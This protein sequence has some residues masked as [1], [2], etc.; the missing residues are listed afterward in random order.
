[1]DPQGDPLTTRQIQTAWE[2]CIDPYPNWQFGCADN[3]HRQFS[4][5]S[6]LTLTGTLSDTPEPLVTLRMTLQSEIMLA[7]FVTN[8]AFALSLNCHFQEETACFGPLTVRFGF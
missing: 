2:I 3:L 8:I 1:M 4:K 7:H 5:G 6:V